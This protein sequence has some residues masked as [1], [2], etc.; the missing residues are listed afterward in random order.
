MAGAVVQGR[1]SWF[2]R[3]DQELVRPFGESGR[4]PP[5]QGRRADTTLPT[6]HRH[7]GRYRGQT[8]YSQIFLSDI[9]STL[10][11]PSMRMGA[12]ET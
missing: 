10:E 9:F 3:S 11:E 2:V 1:P 12:V 4:P 7:D 8:R 5:A 6:P